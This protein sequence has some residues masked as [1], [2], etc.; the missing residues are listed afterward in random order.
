MKPLLIILGC[1]RS[2]TTLLS[3]LLSA[4]ESIFIAPETHFFSWVWGQRTI[5]RLLPSELR[6]TL[7]WR[8]LCTA[9]YPRKDTIFLDRKED[10][11]LHLKR[12]RSLPE[13]F[14]SII[15]G[16]S[17]KI[18][19]GEK[20][21]L[22]GLILPKLVELLPADTKFLAITRRAEG[23]IAS[24]IHYSR[25]RGAHS[26]EAAAAR[27]VYIN[28]KL[29]NLEASLHP[30]SF[31][32]LSFESVLRDPQVTLQPVC[33][34]LGLPWSNNLLQKQH[35]QDSSFKQNDTTSRESRSLSMQPLE[36]WKSILSREDT[37]TIRYLCRK[38][39]RSLGY[40]TEYTTTAPRLS[41]VKFHCSLAQYELAARLM[42]LGIYPFGAITKAIGKKTQ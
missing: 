3:Q 6:Y 34:W 33:A 17:D 13:A 1:S 18:V 28:Q 19:S 20:T 7:I 31:Y 38:V 27:W 22:H 8:S 11:I 29:I 30:E 10:I 4:H 40:P 37:N 5:L 26:L 23:N 16:V 24:S 39:S 9:E 32:R 2:G 21:P 14:R 41:A 36:Q 12:S 15:D 25:L 35:F 42:Q